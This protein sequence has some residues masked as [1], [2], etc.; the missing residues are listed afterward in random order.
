MKWEGQISLNNLYLP[1]LALAAEGEH[2]TARHQTLAA[3]QRSP[4][5]PSSQRPTQNP[6]WR[7]QPPSAHSLPLSSGLA[8]CGG[9]RACEWQELRGAHVRPGEMLCHDCLRSRTMP[10]PQS[11]T[12]SV[13][14]CR[15]QSQSSRPSSAR[16][17]RV[18][19]PS[20]SAL[21][22]SGRRRWSPRRRAAV[23]PCRQPREDQTAWISSMARG[24]VVRAQAALLHLSAWGIWAGK[25][26]TLCWGSPAFPPLYNQLSALLIWRAGLMAVFR[27]N[28]FTRLPLHPV[29]FRPPPPLRRASAAPYNQRDVSGP[30]CC[31]C[32]NPSSDLRPLAHSGTPDRL[33]C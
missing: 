24:V 14:E 18:Q 31:A 8:E 20:P 16:C 5:I 30:P 13:A 7:G 28:T 10:S 21:L 17:L 27:I 4:I 9:G 29:L 26:G 2:S 25:R 15:G 22:S 23:Q 32:L 19:A 6:A 3:H 12:S 1:K 11:Q 33:A